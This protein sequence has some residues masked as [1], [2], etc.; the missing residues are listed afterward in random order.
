MASIV[1]AYPKT[2]S[3]KAT[4]ETG[5]INVCVTLEQHEPGPWYVSMEVAG[6][7]TEVAHST[8]AIF[9]G[10]FQA[11]Q[12]FM[13]VREPETIVFTAKRDELADVYGKYLKDRVKMLARMGYRSDGLHR[14]LRRFK[15]S[16]WR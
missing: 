3:A 13:Q 8:D 9:E 5:A 1:W 16:R 14:V 15:P 7:A 10:V 11:V 12:D 2:S 4:F 6:D